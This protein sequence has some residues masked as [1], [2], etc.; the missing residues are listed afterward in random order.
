MTSPVDSS[1][2]NSRNVA[3]IIYD[4]WTMYNMMMMMIVSMEDETASPDS[5]HQP[6]LFTPELIYE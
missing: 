3:Y 2:T 4:G 6:V 1:K 5:C